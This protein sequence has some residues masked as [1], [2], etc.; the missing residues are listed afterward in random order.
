MNME[1]RRRLKG[2]PEHLCPFVLAGDSGDAAQ[3]IFIKGT[4]ISWRYSERRLHSKER[5]SRPP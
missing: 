4:L 1:A 5:E 2:P 3:T